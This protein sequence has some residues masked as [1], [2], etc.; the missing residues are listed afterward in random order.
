VLIPNLTFYTVFIAKYCLSRSQDNYR[1]SK[2]E[3][4]GWMAYEIQI[5]LTRVLLS[6]NVDVYQSSDPIIFISLGLECCNTWILKIRRFHDK[7]FCFYLENIL[8]F[9]WGRDFW[10]KKE[11]SKANKIFISLKIYMFS[12]N[13]QKRSFFR[14]TLIW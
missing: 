4:A 1:S 8:F 7:N 12:N 10:K 5:V 14:D 13:F 9:F 11:Y 6:S 2:N 3:K